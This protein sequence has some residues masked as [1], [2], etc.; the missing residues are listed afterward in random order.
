MFLTREPH[1]ILPLFERERYLQAS[2][3]R[4]LDNFT[5]CLDNQCSV[6]VPRPTGARPTFWN[7]QEGPA[8]RVR[9]D[10]KIRELVV[11]PDELIAFNGF[12]SVGSIDGQ[13]LDRF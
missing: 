9:Q 13:Y 11:Q 5:V 3:C 6:W 1:E 8:I 10:R 2:F 7:N 12:N 4:H